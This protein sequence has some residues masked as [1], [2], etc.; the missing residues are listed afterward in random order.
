MH[1]S[2]LQRVDKTSKISKQATEIWAA[3]K[4]LVHCCTDGILPWL[5]FW[6]I[7]FLFGFGNMNF[8]ISFG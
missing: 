3:V 2:D 4:A 1:S 6:S 5:T 7:N 8:P